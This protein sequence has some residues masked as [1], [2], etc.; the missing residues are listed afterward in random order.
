MKQQLDEQL[1]YEEGTVALPV[2]SFA[3]V[4]TKTPIPNAYKHLYHQQTL[5]F[6]ISPAYAM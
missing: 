3:W 2:C 6:F 5:P 4:Y 1:T